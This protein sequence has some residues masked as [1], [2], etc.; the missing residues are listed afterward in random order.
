MTAESDTY[1]LR[2]QAEREAAAASPLPLR[3]DQHLRSAEAWDG[4]AE[5]IEFT[6]EK[7]LV[8]ARAKMQQ[9]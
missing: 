8:N 4:M 3:K 5:K 9:I 1:R 7:A 6:A 2:A